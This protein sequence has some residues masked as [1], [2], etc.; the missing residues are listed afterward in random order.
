MITTTKKLRNAGNNKIHKE[1]SSAIADYFENVGSS[2]VF[3]VGYSKNHKL[4]Q[5]IKH[6]KNSYGSK[7]VCAFRIKYKFIEESIHKLFFLS[8][9][10]LKCQVWRSVGNKTKPDGYTELYDESTL[11]WVIF[12]IEGLKR[13]DNIKLAS[14]IDF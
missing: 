5:R 4:Y 10:K 6:H 14:R 9:L 1:A 13:L 7:F 8:R 12:V 2:L 3:K 11:S